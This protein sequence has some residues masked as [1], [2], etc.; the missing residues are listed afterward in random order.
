MPVKAHTKRTI[1]APKEIVWKILDDYPTIASWSAGIQKSFT[2]GD[3]ELTTGLGAERRCE[4]GGN[5]VLDEKISAYTPGESM[6]IDVW[7]V[8]GL[9][10]KSSQ[11]TFAVRDLGDGQ[12]EATIDAVAIPKIPGIIV[13][14]L[15]PI[16]SKGLAKNFGGLLDELAAASEQA[17]EEAQR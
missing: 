5:K 7:H 16:I 15:G 8:E 4:L 1:N 3:T 11:A 14:L 2:T 13:T 10:L 12:T 9:P 17:L 6:T